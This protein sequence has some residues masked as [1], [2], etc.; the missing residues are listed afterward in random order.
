[1]KARVYSGDCL[2]CGAPLGGMIST[3]RI[4]NGNVLRYYDC[5]N[6]T[7]A[8]KTINGGP[9]QL[10]VRGNSP[11]KAKRVELIDG[12]ISGARVFIDGKFVGIGK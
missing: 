2:D 11:K 5:A 4:S 3:K 6:C 8:H 1:M 7:C 10:R 12:A 9:M